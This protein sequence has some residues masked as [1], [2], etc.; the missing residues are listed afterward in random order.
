MPLMEWNAKLGVGVRVIDDDHQ[1][2]VG[3]VNDLY[4]AMKSA[5]GKEVLGRVLDG[6]ISYTKT[7]FGREEQLMSLHHYPGADA[8]HREHVAL[9]TK[10][11]EVQAKFKAGNT[12]ILSMEVMN[13]LREWLIKHIQVSDQ[14]LGQFL[15][16]KNVAA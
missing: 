16:S 15:R 3:M 12:A 1:K 10:V 5:Q 9:A 8:H 4:D 13:F 7:H 2:L 11:L 14:A 6:L